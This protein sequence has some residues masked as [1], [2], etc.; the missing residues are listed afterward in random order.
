MGRA[1]RSARAETDLIEIWA[2]IAVDDPGAADRLLDRIEHVCA[3]LATR[4]HTGKQRDDLASGTSAYIRHPLN[5]ASLPKSR[6]SP[7]SL[8][9]ARC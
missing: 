4:P 1:Y 2:G 3:L 8:C 9:A 5:T 6:A 7:R